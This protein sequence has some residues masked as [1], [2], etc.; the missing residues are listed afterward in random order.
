MSDP[1][2]SPDELWQAYS[3]NGDTPPASQAAS[4]EQALINQAASQQDS[5]PRRRK[6]KRVKAESRPVPNM[7][8]VTEQLACNQAR[9]DMIRSANRQGLLGM[10]AVPQLPFGLDFKSVAV[11]IFVGGLV[12]YFFGPTRKR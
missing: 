6:R 3:E 10:G 7:A 11:G 5:V 2:M 4:E 9:L 1:T 12:T 8:R